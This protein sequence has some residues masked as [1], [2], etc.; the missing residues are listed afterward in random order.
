MKIRILFVALP[1][2]VMLTLMTSFS[3][4]FAQGIVG[5]PPMYRC[6]GSQEVNTDWYWTDTLHEYVPIFTTAVTLIGISFLRITGP[7]SRAIRLYLDTLAVM[8]V[9]FFTHVVI[10]W[11]IDTFGGFGGGGL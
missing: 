3:S 8:L 1:V 6:G 2:A 7:R 9:P 5:D 11:M 4:A 10:S